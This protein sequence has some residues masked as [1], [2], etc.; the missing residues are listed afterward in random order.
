MRRQLKKIIPN[1]DD[2]NLVNSY[3]LPPKGYVFPHRDYAIDGMGLA[4]IYVALK[5]GKGNVFGMYGCGDIPIKEG[6]VILLNNYTLPH[7]VYNGS[8]EDRVVIDIS[9]NLHSPVIKDKIIQAF[10]RSFV[11]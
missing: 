6:D 8:D 1:D 10:K 3:S 5:W 2:I 9:A 11:H 4:K 7:W